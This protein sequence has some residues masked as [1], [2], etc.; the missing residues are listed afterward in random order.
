MKKTWKERLYDF[1]WKFRCSYSVEIILIGLAI[2]GWVGS[3]FLQEYKIL[4]VLLAW[5]PVLVSVCL[6]IIVRTKKETFLRNKVTDL[7]FADERFVD[8]IALIMMMLVF[9]FI[10][11]IFPHSMIW[12]PIIIGLVIVDIVF[13]KQISNHFKKKMDTKNANNSVKEN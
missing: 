3:F 7:L 2:G 1:L 6:S 10:V 11:P 12:L 8:I 5:L 4:F 13:S 9:D